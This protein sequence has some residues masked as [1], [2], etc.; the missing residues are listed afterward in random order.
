VLACLF[1]LLAGGGWQCSDLSARKPGDESVSVPLDKQAA[2]STSTATFAGNSAASSTPSSSG[3][4]KPGPVPAKTSVAA[5]AAAGAVP[6]SP[7]SPAVLAPAAA[8]TPRTEP[9]SEARTLSR[10]FSN[11]ARAL[12]PSVVRVD[13]E[14]AH[15]EA[16]DEAGQDGPDPRDLPPQLRRF[17][18]F[19][20]PTEPGPQRGTGSGV[21][22]DG[23]GNIVT[24]RHVVSHASKVMVTFP[25][26][27][28]LSAR[29]VGADRQ[30]DVAVVRLDQPPAGLV[31]ARLGDS[32]K[33]DVGE[34]VLAVG[35]PLGLDQTVTAGIVS[36]KG[37]V[38]RHVQMSGERVR[39][40][41]QT[42]AK[43]NPGNSG[44]PLVNLE[45][46]V[47][48]IN[49]LINTGPGGAYGFAIPINQV[50]RV[51]EALIKDG[52]VRYPYLGVLLGDVAELDP[53]RR[54]A[55]TRAAGAPITGAFVSDV[56]AGG[57][58]LHAG[59]RTGDVIREI[60]GQV[61]E[62]A[63]DVIDYV[64]TRTIGARVQVGYLR[65]GKTVNVPIVLAELPSRPG[66][67]VASEDQSASFGL[68]LQT[69]TPRLADSLGLPRSVKGAV[70]VEA[71]PHAPGGNA[72]SEL[73]AG[74][75]IVEIDRKPITSGEAARTA[76]ANPRRRGH[77][78]RVRGPDGIRFVTLADERP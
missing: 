39:H 19:G 41:I 13:V 62:G 64:S 73:A 3:A 76:L 32:D 18:Q 45:S 55:L 27:R 69:L 5:A 49:T 12:G 61:M 68:S 50:R 48:G 53:E 37:R 74:D 8:L 17:F 52:R 72:R 9:P 34:W 33:L 6:A 60:D 51:A 77:L 4:S 25:D 75:V 44:G 21:V 43:I 36:G 24:N 42:D 46:E 31:A 38:G 66:D 14:V 22:L 30:T 20:Q 16:D 28:E 35:S 65:N 26:G 47:V 11:V 67:A 58:A 10:A 29:V 57:P 1:V 70:V 23:A 71:R 40:Y 59:L 7:P 2:T 54:I 56:T 63:S 15:P 78:L